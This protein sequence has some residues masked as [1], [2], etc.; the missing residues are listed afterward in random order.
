MLG[1]PY[2]CKN[3]LDPCRLDRTSKMTDF[4]MLEWL[5]GKVYRSSTRPADLQLQ[6]ILVHDCWNMLLS[7]A[8]YLHR[9]YSRRGRVAVEFV[10]GS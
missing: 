3:V 10:L 4:G 7:T 9:Y 6:P 5:R 1:E 8:G 2:L